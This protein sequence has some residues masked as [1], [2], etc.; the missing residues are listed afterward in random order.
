MMDDLVT[1]DRDGGVATVALNNP[2]RMNAFSR[3]MRD[4]LIA[5]FRQL[6]EDE[7]CR[8]IVLTGAGENFSAGGDLS[9]FPETSVAE[10]R[11]RLERGGA[12]L[13]REM[14]AG[15]KPIIAAVEG[16]AYGAGLALTIACDHAVAARSAKFCCAFTRVAFMPD[17]AVMFNLPRRVG[18]VRAKQIIAL[19]EVIGAEEALRLGIV[20]TLVDDAG[21]LSAAVALAHRYA[22]T[23]PIAFELTKSVFARGLEDMIQAE[24]DLQPMAWLSADHAEGKKAFFEKR[25]PRFTG[26]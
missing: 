2:G 7:T 21:A 19:A 5:A 6:N 22:Q 14:V 11:R 20:D 12:V 10:C 8:A 18:A 16:N 15:P 4:Q 13:M 9:D 23:P 25:K 1:V 24:I 17:L 3:A 26:R